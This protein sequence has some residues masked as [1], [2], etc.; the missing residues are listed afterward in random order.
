MAPASV[1]LMRVPSATPK[2]LVIGIVRA[3]SRTNTLAAAAPASVPAERDNQLRLNQLDLANQIRF[4]PLDFI[5]LRVAVVGWATFQHVR[6]KHFFALQ[7]KR[8]EHGIQ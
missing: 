4:A 2:T 8:R 3:T 5:R 7:A 1:P 6:N